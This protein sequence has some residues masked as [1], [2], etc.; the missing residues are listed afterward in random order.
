MKITD[1]DKKILYVLAAIAIVFCG[2]F[3][4]YRNIAKKS[5]SLDTEIAQLKVQVSELRTMVAQSD[6]YRNETM[7]N[8]AY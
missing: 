5:D 1:R 7:K 8:E 4:G 2:W 3:F 6:M